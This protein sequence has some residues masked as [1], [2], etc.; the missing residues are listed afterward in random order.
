M[1]RQSPTFTVVES[2]KQIA[3][4]PQPL[5]EFPYVF[6]GIGDLIPENKAEYLQAVSFS[7]AHTSDCI[8]ELASLKS[9]HPEWKT[10]DTGI[11]DLEVEAL[12]RIWNKYKDDH[13]WRKRKK[14]TP[15][16]PSPHSVPKLVLVT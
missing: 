3:H 7:K 8:R 9:E 12:L 6:C 2:L 1:D 14:P 10:I 4:A 13:D 5:P 11:F 15:P 16:K